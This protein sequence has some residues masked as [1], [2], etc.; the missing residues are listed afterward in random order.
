MP[1]SIGWPS[2]TGA[3]AGASVAR[4]ALHGHVGPPPP[5][6]TVTVTEPA[7]PMLPLSSIPRARTVTVPLAGV[8]HEN[9]QLVV[10]FAAAHVAPPSVETSTPATTPPTSDAVPDTVTVA[11]AATF[12]PFDGEA[13]VA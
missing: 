13:I 1:V 9:V 11:F 3:V 8:L 2:V 12:A 6:P 4:N 10:P 7:A 5:L